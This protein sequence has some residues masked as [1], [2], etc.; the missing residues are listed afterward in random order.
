MNKEN[1]LL[2]IQKNKN[3]YLKRL[4]KYKNQIE[5]LEKTISKFDTKFNGELAIYDSIPNIEYNGY[6]AWYSNDIKDVKELSIEFYGWLQM[7][8]KMYKKHKIK[9]NGRNKTVKVFSAVNGE[10]LQHN[11]AYISKQ[12]SYEN[13]Y[14]AEYIIPNIDKKFFFLSESQIKLIKKEAIKFLSN[15]TN[16]Y[17]SY[18]IEDDYIKSML[19][20]K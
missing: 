9:F 4:E 12:P 6:N 15:N 5:R 11:I 19:V 14:C 17:S 10:I 2:K 1:F 20:F 16:K 7:S 18:I 3:I 8:F 13:G